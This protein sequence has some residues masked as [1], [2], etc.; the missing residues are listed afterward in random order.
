MNTAPSNPTYKWNP[1]KV[2]EDKKP[3]TTEVGTG[4]VNFCKL[5]ANGEMS[6]C[7][8]SGTKWANHITCKFATKAQNMD[9]CS[10]LGF[11]EF[12]KCTAAQDAAK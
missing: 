6:T 2:T 1:N 3:E 12:C 9:R 5:G 4:F 10:D 7:K 8:L 11:G